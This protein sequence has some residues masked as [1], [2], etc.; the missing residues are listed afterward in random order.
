[1]KILLK[2]AKILDITSE[3]HNQLKDILI[4]NGIYTAIEN[5]LEDADAL[6][7][8]AEDLHVS[9]GWV[10]L[11]TQLGDPG[12][13]H[14]ET[15]QSGLD[16]AAFGGFTHVCSLPSTFPVSDGKTQIEYQ[17]NRA[18]D[19]T[20]RLH[21]I[22]AI[23]KG[24][25]G[26]E[27]AEMFDMSQ[28]GVRLFSDDL[29]P[30]SSGI[31]YRALLYAKNFG[32]RIIG[33]SRD[34]SIA[35]KGMVNEGMASTLTGLKA[36][37]AIAE[38]IQVE[39]NLRLLEYTGG[40]I[41]LTGISCEESVHLIRKA[42]KQGLNVTADVHL[43]NLVFNEMDMQDFNSLLKVMPVLR[44]EEDR[45]ALWAGLLD[46][47]ID[48][49][50]SDHRPMDQEE[51]ELEF[52]NASFGCFQLQTVFGVLNREKGADLD[53]LLDAL[54]H[55][56]RKIA[57]IENRTIAVGQKADCTVFDPELT[58]IFN[59]ENCLASHPYSPFMNQE[60]NGKVLAVINGSK[61]TLQV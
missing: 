19:H 58:W 4:E 54:S 29:T 56:S 40:T 12:F 31:M 61:A 33:F 27:L 47:T 36:D 48:T 5:H 22:G 44:R 24:L 26:E 18:A 59:E 30:V 57:G 10:D 43:M 32:G 37:A 45:M 20:V 41:H 23:T 35:G 60:M 9:Q 15:I 52:D 55:R 8:Q 1:M 3:Y 51:K 34:Y 50:V 14:K 25:K 49:V 38:I 42:K 28:S 7:I 21:P 13:E 39:R 53:V 46:G 16:Q 2:S 6:L 11:K 17:L